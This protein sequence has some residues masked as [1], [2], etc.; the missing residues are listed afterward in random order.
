M[1]HRMLRSLRPLLPLI[2]HLLQIHILPIPIRN[3]M[4]LDYLPGGLGN[5]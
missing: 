1:T 4:R 2:I 3:R 5:L